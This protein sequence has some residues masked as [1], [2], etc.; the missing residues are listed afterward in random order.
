MQLEKQIADNTLVTLSVGE[1]AAAFEGC[2][3]V[4]LTGT[5]NSGTVNV[6]G[7]TA[8]CELIEILQHGL[9]SRM[10]T[11][12]IP[13]LESPLMSTPLTVTQRRVLA[14]LERMTEAVRRDC[15]DAEVFSEVLDEMLTSLHGNDFFG[16]EGQNDPRGDFRNGEWS[17]TRVEG[18]DG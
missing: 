8:V 13:P 12:L 11:P 9:R 4:A 7:E 5:G 14:V 3:Q 10:R 1:H 2:I 15:D 17:M 18:I 6:E 16:T